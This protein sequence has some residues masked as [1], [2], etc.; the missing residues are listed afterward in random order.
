MA[1]YPTKVPPFPKPSLPR[2]TPKISR[3][4]QTLPQP[5]EPST[6]SAALPLEEGPLKVGGTVLEG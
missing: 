5:K 4:L 6:A 1:L 2:S 3:Y